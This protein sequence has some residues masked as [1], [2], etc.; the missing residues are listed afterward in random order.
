MNE[1]NIPI[2]SHICSHC[3]FT[4]LQ[5]NDTMRSTNFRLASSGSLAATTAGVG[6][7]S[8]D[9]PLY[10]AAGRGLFLSSFSAKA[11][12]YPLLGVLVS[13][14]HCRHAF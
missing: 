2:G 9:K 10:Q 7:F 8:N 4:V 1:R 3:L 14:L 13:L 12:P 11:R 5:C 6:P